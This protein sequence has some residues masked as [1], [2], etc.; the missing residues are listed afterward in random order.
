MWAH[1]VID[2]YAQGFTLRQARWVN[3]LRWL[4]QA[5]GSPHG[6]VLNVSEMYE[7]S[8]V[9]AAREKV[10][11]ANPTPEA[12]RSEVL[13]AQLMLHPD[14]RRVAQLPSVGVLPAFADLARYN[15]GLARSLRVQD[16]AMRGLR[17]GLQE[18]LG[19]IQEIEAR[20]DKA[21]PKGAARQY[22]DRVRNWP[23]SAPGTRPRRGSIRRSV[24]GVVLGVLT[25]W[26]PG[27]LWP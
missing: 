6:E 3:H 11:V 15:P 4:P 21:D 2:S 24:C 22:A 17:P 7:F 18:R 26:S 12:M 13:D 9:Y 5:G 20:F 14:V 23:A 19:P 8:A 27:S 1:A 10:A 16:Q 25:R